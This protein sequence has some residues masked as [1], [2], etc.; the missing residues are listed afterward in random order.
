[1]ANAIGFVLHMNGGWMLEDSQQ[2]K[3]LKPGDD[4]PAGATCRPVG[5]ED[6]ELTVAFY[7]GE[8][9]TLVRVDKLPEKPGT[10]S[11]N[12]ITLAA[13][14]HFQVVHAVSRGDELRDGVIK[15]DDGQADLSGIFQNMRAD[16]YL[17]RL[18]RIGAEAAAPEPLPSPMT[19]TWDPAR[20]SQVTLGTV[21]AGL[22]KF[23]LLDAHSE[24]HEPTGTEAAVLVSTPGDYRRLAASFQEAIDLTKRWKG[25]KPDAIRSFLRAYLEALAEPQP[26]AAPPK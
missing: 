1:M 4:L 5:N 11:F 20:P 9:V 24:G 23:S 3:E 14:R 16:R 17:V 21:E 15:I 25:V 13:K 26:A 12:R 6:S 7:D 19:I 8:T 22:Y 10:S 18:R 2:R